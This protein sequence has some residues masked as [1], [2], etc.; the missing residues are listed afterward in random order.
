MNKKNIFKDIIAALGLIIAIISLIIGIRN[1]STNQRILQE[2]FYINNV[3]DLTIDSARIINYPLDTNS[4]FT[5]SAQ[6]INKSNQ[7][8]KL[9]TTVVAVNP[10]QEYILRNIIFH[11]S[12][13]TGKL[14]LNIFKN[15]FGNLIQENKTT[16]CKFILD[17]SELNDSNST[18]HFYMIFKSDNGGYYDKYAVIRY[19]SINTFQSLLAEE[20][21]KDTNAVVSKKYSYK[22]FNGTK[23]INKEA[24]K[25]IVKL[26]NTHKIGNGEIEISTTV[27]KIIDLKYD[28]HIL[29][30][31]EIDKISP[32][33]IL[34]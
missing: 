29:H 22:T 12:I 14:H 17:D 21:T 26:Y 9:I 34:N 28:T 16:Y 31:D 10:K 33:F 13:Y 15:D 8:L 3:P 4:L 20:L 27:F 32:K 30:I 7:S 6:I 23:T 5:F 24:I 18:I 2:Q 25:E 1:N 19:A 11:D